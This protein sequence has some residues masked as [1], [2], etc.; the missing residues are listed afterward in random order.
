M[1]SRTNKNIIKRIKYLYNN[2][3][4][5]NYLHY[6]KFHWQTSF[7]CLTNAYTHIYIKCSWFRAIFRQIR[8]T[9]TFMDPCGP[10]LVYAPCGHISSLFSIFF[11]SYFFP[12]RL[13]HFPYH[14]Q[15]HD[16]LSPSSQH[17]VWLHPPI[18]SCLLH[19]LL[20][21]VRTISP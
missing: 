17:H 11:L 14:R 10:W 3:I 20:L 2:E 7:T 12:K 21:F 4:D 8:V 9:R 16:R 15:S 18:F 19:I 6:I 5:F 13:Y 1:N